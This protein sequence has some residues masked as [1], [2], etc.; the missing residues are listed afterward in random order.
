MATKK[1]AWIERLYQRSWEMELLISG[2]VVVSLVQ[3]YSEVTGLLNWLNYNVAEGALFTV[4]ML[5]IVLVPI[6]I[7]SLGVFFSL[8]LGLRAYWIA[9]IGLMSRNDKIPS[10]FSTH[11]K[12]NTIQRL[13]NRKMK[14]HLDTVDHVGSQVF[15]VAFLFLFYFASILFFGIQVVLLTGFLDY[16]PDFFEYIIGTIL[17]VLS[18]GWLVFLFDMLTNGFIGRR[19]SPFI[20][21]PFYII[22][23][24]FR[25]ISGYF[26]YEKIAIA[27]RG[28]G[29]TTSAN[30]A[31]VAWLVFTN[32]TANIGSRDDF[33]SL[34]KDN[35]PSPYKIVYLPDRDTEVMLTNMAIDQHE[36]ST[37]PIKLFIPLTATIVKNLKEFCVFEEGKLLVT[38][39]ANEFFS[40]SLNGKR[41]TDSYEF[42]KQ[43]I[44]RTHGI[45]LYIDEPKLARGKHELSVDLPFLESSSNISFHYYPTSVN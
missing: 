29:I 3:A 8:N 19:K 45:M 9:L 4:L 10:R 44:N 6:A 11:K 38:A 37:M 16:L 33:L 25:L 24:Y 7:I 40:I 30:I 21:K 2:F 23:R 13:E 20:H 43:R 22:Y 28:N 27:G 32:I 39:C 1:H 34:Q 18:L 31:L 42:E 35:T 36:Y 14:K 15:A 26:L 5:V 17:I 41:I 12:Q